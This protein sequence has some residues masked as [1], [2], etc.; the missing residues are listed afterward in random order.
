MMK[1]V[2][3]RCSTRSAQPLIA[4]NQGGVNMPY[5]YG[6]KN[7]ENNKWY[8]GQTVNLKS[9]WKKHKTPSKN[10]CKISTL[11]QELG[12]DK[13]DFV[14]IE[15]VEMEL[16]DEKEIFY[17]QRYNSFH[18][19]YNE[20]KGGQKPYIGQ[21]LEVEPKE[22]MEYYFNNPSLSCREVAKHFGIFHETVS[23]IVK[24]SGLNLK[25]LGA[26]GKPI[27]LINTKTNETKTFYTCKDAAKYISELGLY[28]TKSD[29][30]RKQLAKGG[31]KDFT[32]KFI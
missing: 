13:F 27:T 32:V 25:G 19:G 1:S 26:C 10:Q 30:I 12:E 31:Y 6:I 18:D 3:L 16:L 20:T 22:I 17:I 4:I 9:R 2:G 11:I 8:I 7:K 28:K 29:T 5:I 15:E 24:E 23:S 21:R 14:V